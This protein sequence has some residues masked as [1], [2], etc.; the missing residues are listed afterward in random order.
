MS[1]LL[2]ELNGLC[3]PMAECMPDRA[4]LTD[5][6]LLGSKLAHEIEGLTA[7]N[8][9][10][11]AERDE[12][13]RRAGAAEREMADLTEEARK[14]RWWLD[15]AKRARGYN[16]NTSFDTVW[17]ETCAKA[18]EAD[19][20]TAGLTAATQRLADIRDGRAFQPH[21]HAAAGLTE[22]LAAMTAPASTQVP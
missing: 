6:V 5:F 9:R 18:D 7:E 3:S 4:R 13:D 2:T 8:A 15:D 1:N 11:K 14:R 21:L 12:A 10:L 22:I 16:T 19:R 17:A 20:L